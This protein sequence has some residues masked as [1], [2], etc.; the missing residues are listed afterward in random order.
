MMYFDKHIRF[1]CYIQTQIEQC[2]LKEAQGARDLL[3]GTHQDGAAA[4][5][6]DD[7]GTDALM[8]L[9]TKDQLFQVL[10]LRGLLACNVMQHCLQ[11]RHRVDY[12]VNR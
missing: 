5:A 6:A 10:A 9:M 2:M 12:G 7:Q 11:K 8:A 4:A 1:A 3:L